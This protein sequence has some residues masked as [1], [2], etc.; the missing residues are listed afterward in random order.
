M[1]ENR[2]TRASFL[3]ALVITLCCVSL[4]AASALPSQPYFLVARDALAASR[5]LEAAGGRA[6]HIFP[7]HVIFAAIDDPR[8]LS[9]EGLI[10][11]L[12]GP[13]DPGAAAQFGEIA[14]LAAEAWNR[15]VMGIAPLRAEYAVEPPPIM[16]DARRVENVLPT[17]ALARSLT[18][19]YGAA[20]YD[21]SEFM[22]GKVAV[23]IFLVESTGAIDP[24]TEDWTP[25]RASQAISQIQAG[26]SWW[27]ARDPNAHLTF[28]YDIHNPA[29]TSY[30]PINRSSDD[31]G[32]WISEVLG[33][34]GYT[35]SGY[36]E[37]V[38]SYL[39]SIRNSLNT[40]WAV[41]LWVADS[42]N[43]ADGEFTDGYFAYAY[44]GGPL[45]VMTYDND[46]YG[47]SGMGAVTAHEC[48][49]IFYALDEYSGG[50][51]C[52]EHSGY[53]NTPN[54]NAVDCIPPPPVACIMRGQITPYTGRRLRV[55]PPASRPPGFRR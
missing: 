43:D 45:M 12:Q 38:F 22:M 54:C 33:N 41:S 40:D 32:L 27:Q 42:A 28:V 1:Q 15:N 8:A 9:A 16:D 50:G 48:G 37:R 46:A 10:L 3:A 17:A 55:H 39:N 21:T 31:E 2:F 23:G 30:E 44:V 35:D 19:P 36:F 20:R 7:P 5:S 47:I 34:L 25:A 24:S 11:A 52:S 26:L 18:A 53:F 29:N 6:L 4:A 13:V 51:T 14:R 49:H